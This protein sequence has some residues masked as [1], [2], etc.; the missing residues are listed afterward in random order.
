MNLSE[1]ETPVLW[2]VGRSP[3]QKGSA[4]FRQ[5]DF[6]SYRLVELIAHGGMGMV[7][8]ARQRGL[9]REVALK[10]LLTGE[11]ASHEEVKRFLN[12]ARAA[13]RLSHPYIVP[14]HEVG[15]AAG[16]YFFTMDLVRGQPL[17]AVLDKERLPIKWS[18]AMV[19]KVCLAVHY[20]HEQ[21]IV[22]RDIKPGNILIDAEGDPHLTDFGLAKSIH[23]E[24]SLNFTTPGTVLGT[25]YY[26]SPEQSRGDSADARSDVYSLGAVL[27][28]LLTGRPPFEGRSPVDLIRRI[29]ESDPVPPRQLNSKIHR[30]IETITLKALAKD[31]KLRYPTALA[32]AEDLGRYANGEAIQARPESRIERMARRYRR[33]PLPA[34]LSTLLLVILLVIA[35]RELALYAE[36]WE[37]REKLLHAGVEKLKQAPAH[38]HQLDSQ[39]DFWRARAELDEGEDL[40][41]QAM[42]AGHAQARLELEVLPEMRAMLG[43]TETAWNAR[44]LVELEEAA[45]AQERLWQETCRRVEARLEVFAGT[46]L[47]AY[48][49]R[50]RD[51]DLEEAVRSYSAAERRFSAVLQDYPEHLRARRDKFTALL[52]AGELLGLHGSYLWARE[53]L[54]EALEMGLDS[55]QVY[56]ML[57]QLD[58]R[59]ETSKEF[60]TKYENGRLNL[61]KGHYAIAIDYF[62]SAL[63]FLE[64]THQAA[65]EDA[66]RLRGLLREA[67]LGLVLREAEGL[68]RELLLAQ[69]SGVGAH[70]G[71]LSSL[72]GAAELPRRLLRVSRYPELLRALEKAR[73]LAEGEVLAA[74]DARIARFRRL[75]FEAL[76]AQVVEKIEARLWAEAKQTLDEIPRFGT[77]EP[78][79]ERLR[80]EIASFESSPADMVCLPRV[81]AQLGSARPDDNNPLYT[82]ELE[83]FF[84]DKFEV[85]NRDYLEFINAQGYERLQYWPLAFFY[86]NDVDES[87][88]P[89]N[90]RLSDEAKLAQL[91]QLRTLHVGEGGKQVQGQVGPAIWIEGACPLAGCDHCRG[92]ELDHPVRGVSFYEAQ[93]Y[94]RFVGKRLPTEAEWE[95]AA[96]WDDSDQ[97]MRTYPWGEDFS[98]D[99]GRFKADGPTMGHFPRD[100]SPSGC[101][102]MGGNVAEW[103]TCARPVVHH[104]QILFVVGEAILRGGSYLT[105][106]AQAARPSARQHASDPSYR[107]PCVGFRCVQDP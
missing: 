42:Q 75:Q 30:D 2:R 106:D 57:G 44:R 10:V 82:V 80:A 36:K 17:D 5:R 105:S 54:A 73:G 14:I 26:M 39:E 24:P 52:R 23:H 38:W 34:L 8:R 90:R 107:S 47:L 40:I 88:L 7:Y 84:I 22:H 13:A 100:S 43:S 25:P 103:T 98:L 49:E 92:V 50:V 69:L 35:T 77:P 32:M 93:A 51:S 65:G 19:R 20:A 81:R 16:K 61:D 87:S 11:D 70:A 45:R 64:R 46:S 41:R 68:E 89:E 78:R 76:H 67:N 58:E 27:Y 6:G 55:L 60:V 102:H 3:P 21:G 96:R 97:V 85:S 94:A 63:Q 4:P 9:D 28:Q 56:A 91:R 48:A 71:G 37:L 66:E 86:G 29:S 104:G 33:N 1:L 62:K 31:S 83:T 18:L 99:R 12:E 101:W 59:E 72:A 79:T 95:L 15:E 74:L 53:K